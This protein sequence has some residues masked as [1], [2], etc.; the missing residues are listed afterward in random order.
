MGRKSIKTAKTEEKETKVRFLP[1]E[2]PAT[3]LSRRELKPRMPSDKC[4]LK[5][6]LSYHTMLLIKIK[7]KIQGMKQDKK[8]KLIIFSV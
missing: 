8:Q 1:K 5:V 3:V 6:S 4:A 7:K 2:A